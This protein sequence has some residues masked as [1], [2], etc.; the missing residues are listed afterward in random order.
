[1]AMGVVTLDSVAEPENVVDAEII[2]QNLFHLLPGEVWIARLDRTE[3]AF[4][5]GHD[6]TVAVDV[7]TAALEYDGRFPGAFA[8]ERRDVAAGRVVELPVVVFGPGIELP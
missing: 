7:D 1:M 2:G 6:P 4:F 5:G 3:E 8:N